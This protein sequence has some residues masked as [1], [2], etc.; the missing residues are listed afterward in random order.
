MTLA[1]SSSVLDVPAKR[2][3]NAFAV[4]R[5]PLP[6]RDD[7][8]RRV[9]LA[10]RLVDA[11]GLS[12]MAAW[13]LAGVALVTGEDVVRLGPPGGP[14]LEVDL[15]RF[16]SDWALAV[17]RVKDVAPPRAAGRPQLTRARR[18]KDALKAANAYGLDLGALAEGLK[19]TPEERLRSLDENW[20]FLRDLKAGA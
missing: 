6:Y 2:I 17:A 11:F 12:L 19:K 5:R 16:L 8:V 10:F 9:G 1:M 15:A 18:G 3:Q 13:R 14:V 7:D 4:L 20:R